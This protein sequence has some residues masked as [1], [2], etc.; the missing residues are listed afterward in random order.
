MRDYIFFP[1]APSFL[2]LLFI[3][4]FFI[5]FIFI[6][7]IPLAFSKLGIPPLIAYSIFFLSIIGSTINIPV[8]E[9]ESKYF[10]LNEITFW[11]IKYKIPHIKKTVIAVNFG[12]AI[13][14]VAI[15]FYEIL[16]I[17]SQKNHIL[18]TKVF[19]AIIISSLL[20]H[21]IAKP[22][23]GVGIAMPVLV[24]PLISAFLGIFM[25][26]NLRLLHTHLERSEL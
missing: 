15:S 18:L 26:G 9:V 5:F 4:P 10:H 21:F 24:P 8:K 23:K 7:G 6:F 20:F 11:G 3:L 14:P 25:G 22:V 13:I 12:G 1:Y 19:I 16:R 2:L 17:L